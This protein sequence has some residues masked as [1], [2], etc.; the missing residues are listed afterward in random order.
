VSFTGHL[1][2]IKS[3]LYVL[4]NFLFDD[5]CN[6]L[7]Q[8]AESDDSF[9]RDR[10][11]FNPNYDVKGQVGKYMSCGITKRYYPDIWDASVADD[12]GINGFNPT[13][14]QLNKYEEGDFITPHRDNQTSLYTVV[15]PLQ[16]DPLNNLVFGDP[17]AF[18]D[19]IPLQESNNQGLT[20][21]C[22]DKKG[23]G[24]RFDGNAPV[25]WVP[26]VNSARYSA[27][28]LYQ[29]VVEFSV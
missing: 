1:D 24:Y 10:A 13:E 9:F 3:S 25:H 14:I 23:I 19:K 18:Y 6:A 28:F 27:T 20:I 16:T 29:H 22:P 8:F 7:I 15:V 12:K 4:D 17:K 21:S 5:T 11:V 2:K 26:P